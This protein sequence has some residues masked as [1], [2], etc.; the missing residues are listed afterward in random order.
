V[1]CIVSQLVPF[2]VGALGPTR[3]AVVCI[4]SAATMAGVLA[5]ASVRMVAE[6]RSRV[7]GAIAVT[8]TDK[9]PGPTRSGPRLPRGSGPGHSSSSLHRPSASSETDVSSRAPEDCGD[10]VTMDFGGDFGRD[11][12]QVASDAQA[13]AWRHAVPLAGPSHH[14]SDDEGETAT[15]SHA[16]QAGHGMIDGSASAPILHV[17]VASLRHQTS[18]PSW[19]DEDRTTADEVSTIEV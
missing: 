9:L 16:T 17:T 14:D 19:H 13:N 4:A 3:L 10:A 7:S 11:E 15:S 5:L 8:G 2:L 1:P 18:D 12:P 6:V